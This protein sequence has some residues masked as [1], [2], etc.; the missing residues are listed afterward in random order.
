MATRYC[1]ALMPIPQIR[2]DVIDDGLRLRQILCGGPSSRLS[3]FFVLHPFADEIRAAEDSEV[4]ALSSQEIRKSGVIQLLE[5]SQVEQRPQ[6]TFDCGR[7]KLI[8]ICEMAL[9]QRT[10]DT[11]GDTWR[12]EFRWNGAHLLVDPL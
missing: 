7:D 1:G 6:G 8:E 10:G 9:R 2:I 5:V 11:N 3:C 12:N 4:A